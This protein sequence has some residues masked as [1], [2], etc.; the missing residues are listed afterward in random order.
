V[1]QDLGDTIVL[2]TF[3]GGS[4]TTTL[5][6]PR[7]EWRWSDLDDVGPVGGTPT[8][9]GVRETASL[10]D[11]TM[12]D[13]SILVVVT[14]GKP[15]SMQDSIGAVDDARERGH[16][17]IGIGFGSINER[18]LRRLFGDDGYVATRLEDLADALVKT[19]SSQIDTATI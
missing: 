9:A 17:V 18:N 7:E 16:A 4:R 14:D 12:T 13:E 11:Q 5:T 1:T 2:V 8:A 19:Y 3:Q 10:M 15:N 6:G